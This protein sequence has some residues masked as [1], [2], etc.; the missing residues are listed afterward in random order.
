MM[1]ATEIKAKGYKFK[2]AREYGAHV[3]Y[4]IDATEH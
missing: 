1:N 3:E 4:A 2:E